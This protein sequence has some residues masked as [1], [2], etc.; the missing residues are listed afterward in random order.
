MIVQR[1]GLTQLFANIEQGRV[2]VVVTTHKKDGRRESLN[3]QR[4]NMGRCA[5]FGTLSCSSLH[6]ELIPE[7]V[8]RGNVHDGRPHAANIGDHLIPTQC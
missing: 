4:N 7:D 3:V 2:K 1:N 5:I 6:D 8:N